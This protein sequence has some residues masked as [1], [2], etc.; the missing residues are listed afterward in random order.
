M[1]LALEIIGCILFFIVFCLVYNL[2]C[3]VVWKSYHKRGTVDDFRKWK[4]ETD[5][6]PF[7]IN[8]QINDWKI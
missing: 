5:C 7:Y 3:W 8:L 1:T 4:Q 2:I 6:L